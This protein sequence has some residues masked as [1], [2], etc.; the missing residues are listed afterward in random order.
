MLTGVL[1]VASVQQSLGLGVDDY[2]QKPFRPRVL[3]ARVQAKLRRVGLH[4]VCLDVDK[5][6][7]ETNK[8]SLNT[9]LTSS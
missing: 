6:S 7:F 1:E 4:P 2:I 9:S 5:T 3:L 8:D